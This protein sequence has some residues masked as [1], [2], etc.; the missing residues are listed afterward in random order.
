MSLFKKFPISQ[1]KSSFFKSI[2]PAIQDILNETDGV[3]T[4]DTSISADGEFKSSYV[5]TPYV[6]AP[7]VKAPYVKAPYVRAAI[8]RDDV[9]VSINENPSPSRFKR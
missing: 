1:G 7:Y 8:K 9:S 5:R 3:L 6:K 4:S 2:H